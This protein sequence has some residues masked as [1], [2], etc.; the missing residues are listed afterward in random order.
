[1][2]KSIIHRAVVDAER[3]RATLVMFCSPDPAKEI[4]P[5]EELVDEGRPR[6]FNKVINYPE[7]YFHYYQQGKRPLDAVRI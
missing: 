3:E 1:M 6:M 5:L 7:T 4:Q 2:C